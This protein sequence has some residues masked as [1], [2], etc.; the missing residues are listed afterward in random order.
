[1]AKDM[2]ETRFLFQP[3]GQGT[4]YLFRMKTPPILIG[5]SSPRTGRP[6]SAEIRESL[7]GTRDLATARRLRDLL[8]GDIQREVAQ[9][10]GI[11]PGSV[12]DAMFIAEMT[13]THVA[14]EDRDDQE[15]VLADMAGKLKL[16][17]GK[18]KAQ[19]WYKIAT[20]S[21][22]PFKAT[23]EDYQKDRKNSL[24]TSSLN[25]LKTAVKEF[26]KF[27]GEEVCLGD[28]DRRMVAKF[29]MEYLPNSKGPK[30]PEGQSP[31]T[32]SKKVS[33]LGQVWVWARKRG[34]LDFTAHNPWD[35]QAPDKKTRKQAAKQRRDFT[36]EETVKLLEGAGKGTPLGDIIRVCLLTGVRLEEVASLEA[37]QVANDFR[38]YEIKKGKTDNA[39]RIVPLVGIAQEA[40]KRRFK[41][42]NG[43]GL[44]FPELK[45]RE[46]TGKRGGA[47]SQQ[48]TRL[49]RDKLGD[50]TD[51]ELVQHSFRHLWRT[52]AGR[53]GVSLDAVLT[54]GGWSLP[55]RSDNTYDHGLE[56]EQ[57]C[58][59]Q[60]KVA[61]WMG[62][63]GYLGVMKSAG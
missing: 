56:I 58:Q 25:N 22:T 39:A 3:R 31:A 1:M 62:G 51:G 9:W 12:G 41:A 40:I 42:V 52:M 17:V 8:L 44:L 47:I 4:A 5:K 27:A 23:C 34:V 24:S 29:V 21:R 37:P 30:A 57:Y 38:W 48:F 10:E 26:C 6:Y 54:M 36:P 32:I 63:K 43:K 14:P 13:R 28:V 49:R 55:K 61:Q 20:G 60:E 53:A 2:L 33:Q 35:E 59:A 19:R 7:Q 50:E 18:K 11:E 46:S 45:V 16:S 15:S